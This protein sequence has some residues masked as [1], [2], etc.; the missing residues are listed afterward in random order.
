MIS[1]AAQPISTRPLALPLTSSASPTCFM[2]RPD[3]PGGRHWSKHT[4]NPPV[5]KL[6]PAPKPYLKPV[7]NGLPAANTAHR[8]RPPA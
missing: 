8:H 4:A 2:I 1:R 5:P 3:T 6:P 7:P